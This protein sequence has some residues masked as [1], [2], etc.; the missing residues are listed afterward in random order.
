[1]TS[2]IGPA[3]N[4]FISLATQTIP[5]VLDGAETQVVFGDLSKYIA[6]VTLQIMEVTGNAEV[7]TIGQNFRREETYSIVCEVVTFAGDQDYVT[8]F[9][10]AMA[11]YNALVIAVD[12]NPWLSSSGLHDATAA[13]RF[14]EIGDYSIIPHAVPSGKSVCSLQFHVRCSARVDSLD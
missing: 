8:R 12:R 7:A 6:P 1:M 13:V 5:A 4:N 2:S 11:V 14:A 3:V 9:N 10:D